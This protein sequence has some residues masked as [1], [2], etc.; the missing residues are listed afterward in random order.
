METG[1]QI[2]I[3][4]DEMDAKLKSSTY[5]SVG[6]WAEGPAVSIWLSA[7]VDPIGEY[8]TTGAPPI[9]IPEVSTEQQ[10]AQI[11]LFVAGAGAFVIVVAAFIWVRRKTRLPTPE[12]IQMK[13]QEKQQKEYARQQEEL[14]LQ[15]WGQAVMQQQQQQQQQQQWAQQQQQQQQQQWGQQAQQW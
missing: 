6:C 12:E 14:A 15:P 2:I 11:G 8:R 4:T 3:D 5:Q 9:V 13:E 7:A 1:W 10:A